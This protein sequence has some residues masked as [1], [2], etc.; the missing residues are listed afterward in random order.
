MSEDTTPQ[1][2]KFEMPHCGKFT[3]KKDGLYCAMNKI[4]LTL[5]E[6]IIGFHRM[7][8]IKI[9]GESVSYHRWHDEL[10]EWHSLIPW[11][12]SKS[13]SLTVKTPWRDERNKKLLD[14]YG[15]KYKQDFF[16]W[17]TIHTHVDSGAFESGED[18]N[19][20]EDVPGW[21][22][23]LGRLLTAKEYNVHAR[24]RIPKIK[25]ITAVANADCA[26][27]FSDLSTFFEKK[28]LPLATKIRGTRDWEP[29][30]ERV[31]YAT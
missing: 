9:Q 4:P 13:N 29:H 14:D 22:I 20:E 10:K 21:H 7:V 23:T 27:I 8:S 17:C 6:K 15:K 18:A 19:D 28:D 12:N 11:Q 24:I 30:I 16:P 25:K 31:M 3:L 5:W 26:Y 1:M 2:V